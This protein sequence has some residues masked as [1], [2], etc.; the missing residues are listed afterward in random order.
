V[1]LNAWSTYQNGPQ[2]R[3]RRILRRW[4]GKPRTA[5]SR[6]RQRLCELSV[7]E[8]ERVYHDIHGVPYH[9]QYL[10]PEAIREK[11][12]EMRREIEKVPV[13]KRM[14]YYRA[15]LLKPSLEHDD[16]FHHRFLWADHYDC[17]KAARRI[18]DHFT[19]KVALFGTEKLVKRITLD[20]LNEDDLFS[21][22]SGANQILVQ[23]DR[24]G[25]QVWLTCMSGMR[26][27]HWKNQ[28]SQSPCL[29]TY[30]IEY[31]HIEPSNLP[32]HVRFFFFSGSN[33]MVRRH[34]RNRIEPNSPSEWYR[35]H[36]LQ[37][38]VD[39]AKYSQYDRDAIQVCA[40]G[41]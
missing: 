8:R 10:S 36:H 21:L 18:C 3:T 39:T 28:V 29:V 40:H 34:E 9:D 16:T 32:S 41:H 5:A 38:R 7:Q 37:H 33:D 4:D 12:V 2:P 27:K 31:H 11:L 13:R 15:K 14:H 30:R 6:Q 23:P 35:F 1:P 20:D 17:A 19:H 26:Y 25:R 24:S 22:R